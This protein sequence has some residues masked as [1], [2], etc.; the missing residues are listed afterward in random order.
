MASTNSMKNLIRS[1]LRNSRQN[2]VPTI[3]IYPWSSVT[4]IFNCRPL[5]M[6]SPLKLPRDDFNFDMLRE[7]SRIKIL[8]NKVGQ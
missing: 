1:Q 8:K 4:Q 6:M 3:G 7:S 2:V 5:L